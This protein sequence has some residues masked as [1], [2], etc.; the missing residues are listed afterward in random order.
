M[1]TCT[2]GEIHIVRFTKYPPAFGFVL[3]PVFICFMVY[4]YHRS[5]EQAECAASRMKSG[6]GTMRKKTREAEEKEEEYK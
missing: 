3:P 5:Q 1:I 6:R 4:E 2:A